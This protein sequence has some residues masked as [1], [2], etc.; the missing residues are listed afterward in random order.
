MRKLGHLH[1]SVHQPVVP[2]RLPQKPFCRKHGNGQ[3][4]C[5]TETPARHRVFKDDD[6]Q[7]ARVEISWFCGHS[8]VTTTL[9]IYTHLFNT[10][11]HADAMAKLGAMARPKAGTAA[12]NVVLFAVN[13]RATNAAA[14]NACPLRR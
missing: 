5:A 13:A 8:K 11:D 12:N 3:A 9:S 1:R 2:K 14:G 7:V 10:D 6:G 4:V